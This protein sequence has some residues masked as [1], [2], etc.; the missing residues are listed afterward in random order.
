MKSLAVAWLV[1][2]TTCDMPQAQV[3]KCVNANG[4]YTY[5]NIP[6]PAN[7]TARQIGVQANSFGDS[8]KRPCPDAAIATVEPSPAPDS[9]HQSDPQR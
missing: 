4:R 8:E 3:Y 5:M 7:T 2:T 6:C 1:A 9:G